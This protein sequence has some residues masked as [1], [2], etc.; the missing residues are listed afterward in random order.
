MKHINFKNL[1]GPELWS[2]KVVCPTCAAEDVSVRAANTS[3]NDAGEGRLEVIL[4]C[5]LGHA[6]TLTLA[7]RR[8]KGMENPELFAAFNMGRSGA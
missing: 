3:S 2:Q 8:P 7:E 4:E 6:H 5:G 1:L